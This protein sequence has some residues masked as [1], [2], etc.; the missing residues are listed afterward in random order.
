MLNGCLR[1]VFSVGFW[2]PLGTANYTDYPCP[3][4]YYCPAGTHYWN[5]F[6]CP[7]GYFNNVTHRIQQGQCI[8][9]PGK[10]EDVVSL[11]ESHRWKIRAFVTYHQCSELQHK[12]HLCPLV[13]CDA[14]QCYAWLNRLIRRMGLFRKQVFM[15]YHISSIGTDNL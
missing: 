15:V 9:C 8:E 12:G 10:A 3:L 2:C 11:L 14:M 4:G 13:V 1:C 7:A 6:P 5:E